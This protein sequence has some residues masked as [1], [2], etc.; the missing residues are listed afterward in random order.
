MREA[1]IHLLSDPSPS[2]RYRV[3]TELMDLPREDPEVREL[4]SQRRNDPL[5]L[6]VVDAPGVVSIRSAI[7]GLRKLAL[8]GIGRRAKAVRD[9]AE[10][11]FSKQRK[12]GSWPLGSYGSD[13]AAEREGYSMIPLQTSLPLIALSSCGYAEDPRSE[14]G[15]DWLVSKRLEDGTWPTGLSS[16][17]YGGVAGYRRLPHSRWG[18]RSNTT[19]AAIGLSNHPQRRLSEAAGK[20]ADHLLSRRKFETGDMGFETAR[21]IGA[22]KSRGFLTYFARSDP[23]ALL[24]VAVKTGFARSEPRLEALVAA[25]EAE[26]TATGLWRYPAAPQASRWVTFV[27][28]KTL[29]NFTE[30]GRLYGGEPPTPFTEYPSRQ[31]RW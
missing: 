6:D 13:N 10:Y 22:E 28:L 16:G 8:L 11:L 14:A 9:R 24:E 1:L 3:L 19:G 12:D 20:A 25:I 29:K 2:L 17:V 4:Q 21:S 30:A 27:L 26:L 31:R 23:A 7:S 18:C 15:Y 5:Y